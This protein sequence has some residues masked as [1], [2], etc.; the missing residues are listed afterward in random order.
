[1]KE[2]KI[3]EDLWPNHSDIQHV[4]KEMKSQHTTQAE[5]IQYL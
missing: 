5:L 4:E 2:K 3:I 1:M